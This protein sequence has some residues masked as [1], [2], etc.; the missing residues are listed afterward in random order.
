MKPLQPLNQR[1][2]HVG[3]GVSIPT[4]HDVFTVQQIDSENCTVDLKMIGPAEH[5][6]KSVPWRLLSYLDES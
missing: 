2:P 3:D 1:K 4:H 5:W 6:E